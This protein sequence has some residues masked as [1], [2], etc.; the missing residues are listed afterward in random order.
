MSD[1]PAGTGHGRGF[2]PYVRMTARS[3]EEEHRASTPLE[4]LFDLCFVVAVAQ[5][6][7]RLVHAVA[8][9]HPGHGV[10]GYLFVLFAVWWAWVNFTWFASAYDS[11]DVPY[12]IATLV[13][14]AGVLVL[15]A[16]IPR[17]FEGSDYAVA[18]LGYLIMRVALTLQ[19]LRAAH[20][21]TGPA[22]TAALRYAGGLVVVQLCWFALLLLPA[23]AR[24]WCVLPLILAELAVPA[25]AERR[26]MTPWHAEHIAERYGL[27]TIIMLGETIAAAT[28]AVQ[29]ALDESAALGELLPIAAGGLVIVFAAYWIY[30][31]VPV[32]EYL[33]SSRQAFL[34][35]YGHYVILGSAAAI[36][37]GLEV[38]VEE[39][40]HHAHLSTLAA[41]L[42]V[43]LPTALFM[44]AVWAVHA[45]HSKRGLA[46]HLVLPLGAVG[47][48]AASFAGHA[49]VP[50]AGAVAA[51]T[52]AAGVVL[53]E[54]RRP[55]PRET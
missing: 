5:A 6:G 29:S 12:R 8:E 36:G 32:H 15:A 35:G 37:A 43:T 18:V 33:T 45:R 42:A 20:G 13:Q 47:V 50:V 52:V 22:R 3:R 39:A 24:T 11:D 27:F 31:A 14:M 53:A 38:A 51:C 41:S 1:T 40:V 9:G 16:G 49:A 28:V 23:E 46:Q 2:R 17:A 30:F 7:V 21:E 19:W 48:L 4:L 34:W 10:S 44:L 55:A 54:K 26:H 25:F